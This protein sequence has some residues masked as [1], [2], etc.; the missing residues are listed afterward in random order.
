MVM[1]LNQFLPYAPI[2]YN[3]PC[4]PAAYAAEIEKAPHPMGSSGRIWLNQ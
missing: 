1:E 3:A 2:R 4:I